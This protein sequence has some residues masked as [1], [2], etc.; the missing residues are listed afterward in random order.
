MTVPAHQCVGV[1]LA[2][3]YVHVYD[4]RLFNFFLTASHVS[5]L[6]AC[7]VRRGV[8][9]DDGRN[10]LVWWFEFFSV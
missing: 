8:F 9:G 3:R 7:C 2:D 10:T 1:L 6:N 5:A 4:G